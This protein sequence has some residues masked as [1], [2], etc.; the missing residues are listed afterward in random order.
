[1]DWHVW[2]V[3]GE[4]QPRPWVNLAECHRFDSTGH[5]S[6]KRKSANPAEQIKMHNKTVIRTAASGGVLGRGNVGW[7]CHRSD[8]SALCKN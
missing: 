5:L 2:E 8:T 7:R 4:D 3:L 6:R 1:V